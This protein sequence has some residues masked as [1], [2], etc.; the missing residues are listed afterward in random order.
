MAP[1]DRLCA[2]EMCVAWHDVLDF[3]L[4]S[5]RDDLRNRAVSLEN[6]AIE[7][8]AL[9]ALPISSKAE[10]SQ[11]PLGSRCLQKVRTVKNAMR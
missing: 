4:S 5:R 10:V 1:A 6:G 7:E 2:L 11:P 3:L 8:L 9:R